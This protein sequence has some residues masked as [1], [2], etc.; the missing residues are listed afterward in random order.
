MARPTK[1][2]DE[3]LE[4]SIDYIDNYEDKGD[5][6]PSVAGLSVELGIARSTIYEWGRNDSLTEFSD[7]LVKLLSTQERILFNMGLTG[8][9]NSNI[10]KLALTKHGYRDK[11][12]LTSDDK[13]IPT[14]GDTE[15]A[16]KLTGLF[17]KIEARLNESS[18]D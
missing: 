11:A 10:T 14:L 13:P 16:A 15:R 6:M 5:A 4:K 7:M 17:E 12:D 3:M 1:Y 9:F 2:S 8:K 18:E